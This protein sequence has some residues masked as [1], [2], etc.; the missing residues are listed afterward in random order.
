MF[1]DVKY[2]GTYRE[3]RKKNNLYL[4]VPLRRNYR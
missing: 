1:T 4:Q 3:K 2:K